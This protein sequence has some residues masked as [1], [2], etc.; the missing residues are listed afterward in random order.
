MCPVNA[1]T[2]LEVFHSVN[3]HELGDQSVSIGCEDQLYTS[4]C[5]EERSVECCATRLVFHESQVVSTSSLLSS[6]PPSP[7][8]LLTETDAAVFEPRTLFTILQSA[9]QLVKFK[10]SFSAK[11]SKLMRLSECAVWWPLCAHRTR[12]SAGGTCGYQ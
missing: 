9:D 8:T 5:A 10:T 11:W 1:C 4:G 7:Q 6:A 12:T 3:I 2:E